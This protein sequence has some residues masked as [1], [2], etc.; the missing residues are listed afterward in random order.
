[1]RKLF[2]QPFLF[3][4]TSKAICLIEVT[5]VPIGCSNL[6]TYTDFTFFKTTINVANNLTE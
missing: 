3:T 4:Y 1:M 6:F 5:F 2:L